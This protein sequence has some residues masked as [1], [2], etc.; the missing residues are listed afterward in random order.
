MGLFTSLLLGMSLAQGLLIGAI[1]SSTDAA[2]VFSVLRTKSVRLAGSLEPLLEF[3]SGSNDP[4][5]VLLVLGMI[6]LLTTPGASLLDLAPMFALQM[7]LGGG[8]GFVAGRVAAQVMNRLRLQADGLYL[9]ATIT[10]VLLTYSGTTL[11]GGN[12]FLAVYLAGLVMGN[13][14]FVHRRSVANFHD[15][16]AWI[17]QIVMFLTLGLLVFPSRL[18]PVAGAA[19]LT[20]VFLMCVARPAATF[21]SLSWARMPVRE[22]LLV[23]WVGLRGAVP[24]ILATFPLLAGVPGADT[25]FNLVFFVVLTSVLIQGTTVPL[26]GRWLKLNA[27]AAAPAEDGAPLRMPAKLKARLAEVRVAPLSPAAGRQIVELRLPEQVLIVLVSRNGEQRIATGGTRL[28]AGDVLTVLAGPAD[29]AALQR[30]FLSPPQRG[31]PRK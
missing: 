27:P 9:V 30:D 4:M 3:E 1:M 5:A 18:V 8:I 26:V 31:T 20:S 15:G 10:I 12:G 17:M 13:R 7:A 14:D 21:L 19:L 16:L 28:E 25:I 22:L 29:L 2:A 6:Q 23:S 11:L 24:I